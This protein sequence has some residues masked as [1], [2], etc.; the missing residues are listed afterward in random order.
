M[1]H[2][3]AQLG[4]WATSRFVYGPHLCAPFV[5][6]QRQGAQKGGGVGMPLPISAGPQFVF[7]FVQ[8]GLGC[9][10]ALAGV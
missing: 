5:C 9:Y 7:L 6:K 2:L 10:Y 8:T 1:C 4:E 3:C